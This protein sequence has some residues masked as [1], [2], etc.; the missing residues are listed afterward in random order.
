MKNQ[1]VQ[2]KGCLITLTKTNDQ[3]KNIEVLKNYKSKNS[4]LKFK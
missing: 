4:V 2:Y 1:Q 3:V